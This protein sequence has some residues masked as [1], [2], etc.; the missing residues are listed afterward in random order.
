MALG[1]GLVALQ[2]LRK[3]AGGGS[4]DTPV[5]VILDDGSELGTRGRLLF[6]D[7]TVDPSTGQVTTPAVWLPLPEALK[8]TT[9]AGSRGSPTH[10]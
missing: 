5:S 7:V 9:P 3:Q 6:S 8:N 4:R 1:I 2:R 10:A